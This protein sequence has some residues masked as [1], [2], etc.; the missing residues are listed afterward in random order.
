MEKT[1]KPVPVADPEAPLGV[2]AQDARFAA[3]QLR[4]KC[5]NETFVFVTK[6]PGIR[7]ARPELPVCG[8]P[9]GGCGSLWPVVSQ[10]IMA[11]LAISQSVEASGGG[12][13][14]ERADGVFTH[15]PR[16]GIAQAACRGVGVESSEI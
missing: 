6:N 4:V 16:R 1:E 3:N 8:A 10:R 14:P 2:L 5:G 9:E 13:R 12:A 15:R 7:R 11:P